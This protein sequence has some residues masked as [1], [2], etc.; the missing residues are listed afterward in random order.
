MVSPKKRQEDFDGELSGNIG[1]R[2]ISSS[3]ELFQQK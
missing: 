3:N 1:E 2:R